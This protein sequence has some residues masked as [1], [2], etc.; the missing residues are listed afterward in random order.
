MTPIVTDVPTQ[1]KIWRRHW[2][3]VSWVLGLLLLTWVLRQNWDVVKRLVAQPLHWP[4]LV[5]ALTLCGSSILLTFVRWFLL[6]KAQ[7]FSFSIRDALR[8][9]FIGYA[10]NFAFPGA[11][12]GD[13]VKAA[14]I[15]KEQPARRTTAVATILLDRIIGLLALFLIGGIAAWP[16]WQNIRQEPRL[17]ATVA[18]LCGGSIAGVIGLTLMLLPITTRLG[19]WKPFAN[20]PVIG[21]GIA[22]LVEGVRL[23][24]TQKRAIFASMGLSLVGHF[25]MISS[26]YFSAR[27]V[28][29]NNFVPSY[30]AHLFFI[31]A[32]EFVGVVAP[33]PGGLGALE[34]AVDQFYQ[35]VGAQAGT[36]LLTC[37][38][39]RAVTVTVA[40]VG[41]GYY[42]VSRREIDAAMEP[43]VQ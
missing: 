6:V 9:G 12:G 21:K 7:G 36:G 14:L 8:L 5:T 42:L 13:L 1:R 15:A 20:L 29:G 17:Q 3:W 32:A 40:F 11:V 18:L 4:S 19:W 31:P 22:E 27:A 41:V 23:Y 34:I 2:A 33:V 39:Y 35:L 10:F 30:L 26:F 38:A 43:N 16:Q 28:G 25:G 24:Q 37:L